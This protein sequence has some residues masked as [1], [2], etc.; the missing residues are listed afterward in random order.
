MRLSPAILALAGLG[1]TGVLGGLL[2]W[3]PWRPKPPPPPPSPAEIVVAVPPSQALDLVARV[4]DTLVFEGLC[5]TCSV[6][7]VDA[8]GVPLPYDPAAMTGPPRTAPGGVYAYIR[9]GKGYVEHPS[10]YVC[11]CERNGCEVLVSGDRKLCR[12]G[13]EEMWIP[14]LLDAPEIT[15]VADEFGWKQLCPTSAGCD[16]A[17]IGDAL[18]TAADAGKLAAV[19][20][21]AGY[22]QTPDWLPGVDLVEFTNPMGD[23][24][25]CGA[26]GKIGT[27]MDA[28]FLDAAVRMQRELAAYLR[29]DGR[30]YQTMARFEGPI[31][32]A[33]KTVEAK[34]PVAQVPGCPDNTKLWLDLG[35]QPADLYDFQLTMLAVQRDELPGKAIGWGFIQDCCPR[36]ADESPV[37]QAVTM[38]E[39]LDAVLGGRAIPF[40]KGARD[41]RELNRWIADIG[42]T[43]RPVGFQTVNDLPDPLALLGTLDRV[44]DETTS[45]RLAEAY[46]GILWKTWREE[47]P[48]LASRA[49]ELRARAVGEHPT[50]WS[51]TLTTPGDRY[52]TFADGIVHHV[53]VTP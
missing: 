42:N 3:K 19:M 49:A 47:R 12:E 40:H 27:P 39:Q 32:P 48:A 4:H 37:D 5:P 8:D 28:V 45:G 26:T 41:T 35:Y 2:W 44:L 46:E 23:E 15:G 29:A 13:V 53:E 21:R 51:Y 36:T 11:P 6:F 7:E 16:F 33:W 9:N 38:L 10:A 24:A 25:G 34:L 50:T 22:E 30:R 14:S 18:D 17:P 20:I 43:G 1:T 52:F 31:V